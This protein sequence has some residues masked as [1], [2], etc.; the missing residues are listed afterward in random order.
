[1]E[2]RICSHD[3][4]QSII[5]QHFSKSSGIRT[6]EHLIQLAY[7][8]M[9]AKDAKQGISDRPSGH[10]DERCTIVM[11]TV[12]GIKYQVVLKGDPAHHIV[13]MFP[14]DKSNKGKSKQ[15]RPKHLSLIHI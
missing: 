15:R 10:T 2:L 5:K 11:G 8:I 1:M 12:R 13:T 14:L 4:A 6:Y 9:C 3:K 7:N